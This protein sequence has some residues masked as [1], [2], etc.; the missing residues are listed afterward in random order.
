MCAVL[1]RVV[2]ARNGYQSNV[3]WERTLSLYCI[4]I[5]VCHLD[6]YVISSACLLL[7][8]M[9]KGQYGLS[10]NKYYTISLEGY[11]IWLTAAVDE[12]AIGVFKL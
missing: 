8:Y 5:T 3:T 11:T 12:N 6:S 10:N 1:V 7:Y 9:L 2:H 4:Y